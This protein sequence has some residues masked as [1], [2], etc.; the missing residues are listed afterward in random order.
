[1]HWACLNERWARSLPFKF[2][3]H[4]IDNP[5]LRILM[6]VSG[7]HYRDDTAAI[8]RTYEQEISCCN[9]SVTTRPLSLERIGAWTISA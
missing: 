3:F 4:L 1:M 9:V 5:G 6:N 7:K 2:P 8:L